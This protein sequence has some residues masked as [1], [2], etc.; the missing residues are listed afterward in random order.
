MTAKSKPAPRTFVAILHVT[1]TDGATSV[2]IGAGVTEARAQQ[3]AAMLAKTRRPGV[4][5]TSIRR[6]TP[7][8]FE[9]A[10]VGAK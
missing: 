4:R 5:L 3:A 8:E 1:Y 7:D 2:A 9:L 10:H 6:A